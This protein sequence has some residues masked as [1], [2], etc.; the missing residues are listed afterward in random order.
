M[1]KVGLREFRTGM[2]RYVKKASQEEVVVYKH[3]KPLF[4]LATLDE[5]PWEEVIDFT[6]I[7]KG[8]V[9][10]EDLLARL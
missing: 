3:S 4:R 7:R 8:G 2:D 5:E 9:L 1:I 10:I 6:K